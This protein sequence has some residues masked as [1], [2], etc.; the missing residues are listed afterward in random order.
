MTFYEAALE[1]LRQQDQ[2]LHY[3]KITELAL[4]HGLLSHVGRTPEK[5]MVERLEKATAKSGGGDFVEEIHDGVFALREG[6]KEKLDERADEYHRKEKERLRKRNKLRKDRFQPEGGSATATL[7]RPQSFEDQQPP[8]PAADASHVYANEASLKVQQ[9]LDPRADHL[10]RGPLGLSEIAHAALKVLR[11]EEEPLHIQELADRIFDEKL[12]KFHTHDEISTVKA[13]L[14]TDNQMRTREDQRPLFIPYPTHQWGLTEWGLSERNREREETVLS[15]CE[16]IRRATLDELGDAF[17][18]VPGEAFEQVALILLKRLGYKNIKVSKRSSNN[19]VFLTA[20]Q[21]QGFTETRVCIQ[22]TG[23]KS[24]TVGKNTIKELRKTLDHYSASSGVIIHIGKI[25]NSAVESSQAK[26]KLPVKLID[27]AEFVDLLLQ[28]EIG[29]HKL[30]APIHL[31]D[32]GFIERL[33]G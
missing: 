9:A 21:E 26:G 13:A 15:I 33:K 18:D 30:S 25:S 11:N 29:V 12:A 31:I 32:R 5:L 28:H 23:N 16:D 27:R 2:P 17:Q 22:I 20:E 7:Q 4:Q 6:A 24:R 1:I 10:S 19:D 14:V 3:K 8:S